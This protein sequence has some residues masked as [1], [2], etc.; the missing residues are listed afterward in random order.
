MFNFKA[1]PIG[2][3]CTYDKDDAR[4]RETADIHCAYVGRGIMRNK[5]CHKTVSVTL[6]EKEVIEAIAMRLFL[7]HKQIVKRINL[8]DGKVQVQ[9]CIAVDIVK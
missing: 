2:I 4:L 5:V 7:D 8:P 9:G 3:T 6:A 1:K